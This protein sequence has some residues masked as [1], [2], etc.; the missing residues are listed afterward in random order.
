MTDSDSP[1]PP[2]FP[3]LNRINYAR[4]RQ[5]VIAARDL[6][7]AALHRACGTD[8]TYVQVGAHDGVM[9]DPVH[10]A[11]VA[12][13]WKSLLIEPHP[14]YFAAL[15]RTYAGQDRARLVNC[16]IS[17]QPGRMLLHHATE[18]AAERLGSYILGAASLDGAR[19]RAVLA[20]R[21]RRFGMDLDEADIAETDVAVRPLADVLS[22]AGITS[23][24]LLV[25]DAEGHEREVLRSFDLGGFGIR[26]ALVECNQ[27]DTQH[28]AEYAGLLR[29]AGFEVFRVHSDLYAVHPARLHMPLGAVLAMMGFA[30]AAGEAD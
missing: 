17:D 3:A 14:A 25:I 21:A 23:F 20:R 16:A 5:L 15:Q 10:G 26:A 9:A 30:Q 29:A 8:L 27:G 24:D 13:G 1:R 18:A 12:C 2:D 11:A 28:E 6:L 22:E 4:P 19:L 7:M